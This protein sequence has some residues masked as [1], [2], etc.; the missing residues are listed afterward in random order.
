[1]STLS[2]VEKNRTIISSIVPV[3][4]WAR[5]GRPVKR[6]AFWSVKLETGQ[7]YLEAP[8]IF[9]LSSLWWWLGEYRK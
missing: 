1:M 6:L 8:N 4:T 5:R 7:R 2:V 9:H 3:T